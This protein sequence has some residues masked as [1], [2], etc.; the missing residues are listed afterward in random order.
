MIRASTGGFGL[1]LADV[2]V[3]HGQVSFRNRGL[4]ALILLPPYALALKQSDWLPQ[5][6]GDRS[7]AA[8]HTICLVVSLSGLALRVLTAGTV[9]RRTS[10]R[11]K[12]K[13]QVADSLNT[14]GVYSVLRNPLYVA[15]FLTVLGVLMLP[16]V[17]WMVVLGSCLYWMWYERIILAEESFLRGKFGAEY[18]AWAQ[19][20]PALLPS[21]RHYRSPSLP[22]S[23]KTAIKREY[24]TLTSLTFWFLL[25]SNAESLVARRPGAL[26]HEFEAIIL[27]S[28]VLLACLVIRIL[29]QHT[30][31]LHVAGR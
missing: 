29:R 14:T 28:F 10:G 19:R 31:L 25:A 12:A 24:L 23:V 9:P 7:H 21:F 11:N 26:F 2:M 17:W 4:F 18:E 15:N 8:W 30:R 20:T 16:A 3:R 27:G 6:W 13:G 22:F 1:L 5:Q